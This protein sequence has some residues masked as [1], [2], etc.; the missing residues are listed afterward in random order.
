MVASICAIIQPFNSRDDYWLELISETF[1]I[2]NIYSLICFTDFVED[3][4]LQDYMGYV[5][6]ITISLSIVVN[7]GT[8]LVKNIYLVWRKVYLYWLKTKQRWAI[9]ERT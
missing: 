7:L 9:E 5:L 6:I 4:P 2:V 8:I 3:K 1:I